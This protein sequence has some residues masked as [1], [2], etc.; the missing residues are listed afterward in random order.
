MVIPSGARASSPWI[1]YVAKLGLVCSPSEMIGDPVASK[2]L[3][4][5]RI[6]R[7]YSALMSC[8]DIAPAATFPIASTSSGGRGM[9]PIGSVGIGIGCNATGG[10]GRVS[11][12]SSCRVSGNIPPWSSALYRRPLPRLWPTIAGAPAL[13]RR[14]DGILAAPDQTRSIDA[15]TPR[16]WL[17]FALSSV[18][19]GVPYFFI[20][21]A[22]D[23]GVPPAFVAW[24]RV[25]LGAVLLLP[26]ALRRGALRGLGGRERGWPIAAYAACEIAVPFVLISVGEQYI[27]SS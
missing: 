10:R 3:I 14:Q 27:T 1:G 23:A 19:W 21:V 11:N 13:L 25:A 12:G 8:W 4:V 5:S 7:S 26:V 20:K 2:R 24:A 18:I 15:V 6:A 9:L 17:L 16:A 22:V